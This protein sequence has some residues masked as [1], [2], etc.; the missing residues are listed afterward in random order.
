MDSALILGDR[1]ASKANPAPTV[2]T[3]AWGSQYHSMAAWAAERY[4][5]PLQ[6]NQH[7]AVSLHV[8]NHVACK[9][10]SNLGY[11]SPKPTLVDV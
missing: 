5:K 8:V 4:P 7:T 6:A 11:T 2:A 10:C 1:L 3:V 9:S